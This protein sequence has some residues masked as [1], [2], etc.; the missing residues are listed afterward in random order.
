MVGAAAAIDW[1]RASL[2]NVSVRAKRGGEPPA[3]IRSLAA[4]PLQVSSGRR[5]PW[6]PLAVGL[7]A[8][9]THDSPIC[10]SSSMRSRQSSAPGTP[11][12]PRRRPAKLHADKAYDSAG[13][14]APS[15]PAVSPRA[16]PAAGSSPASAWDGTLGGRANVR[17]AVRLPPP[18]DSV[19]A[20]GGPAAGL[21]APG[22][23]S[24]LP[25]VPDTVA[26][27]RGT[28]PA[29]RRATAAGYHP[30]HMPIHRRCHGRVVALHPS[31]GP[32]L[33]VVRP[34]RAGAG[35]AA[36]RR[37]LWPPLRMARAAWCWSGA[38]RASAR[39][40]SS[41]PSPLRRPRAA[42]PS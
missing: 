15:V 33:A 21:V 12:R 13:F 24:A 3:P 28:A 31:R 9:N 7:S 39:P 10:S 5:S 38:R 25:Q 1:T 19:R 16:S 22:L 23:R 26:G 17:L 27:V 4:K 32:S 29:R 42:T 37:A 36:T 8:A 14:A 41:A 2:D 11:G 40:P 20:A 35:A 34:G 30:H 18:R 6:H